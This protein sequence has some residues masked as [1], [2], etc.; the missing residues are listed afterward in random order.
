MN[1]IP[2]HSDILHGIGLSRAFT[3][4]FSWKG[5]NDNDDGTMSLMT[6]SKVQD[7]G[8]MFEANVLPKNE[9]K[10]NSKL[11]ANP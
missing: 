7:I 11:F 1:K 10:V 6:M 2:P 3:I 5:K 4:T 9:Q 8:Q